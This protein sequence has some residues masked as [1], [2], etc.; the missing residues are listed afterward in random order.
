MQC[1]TSCDV[2]THWKALDEYFQMST[3]LL[4]F[5]SF[6]RFLHHFVLA[7]LATSSIRVKLFSHCL[8]YTNQIRFTEATFDIKTVAWVRCYIWT[9]VL[10]TTCY[11]KTIVP[12][13]H[14][15][16]RLLFHG[17]MLPQDYC[18]MATCYLKTIVT[19]QHVT[20]RLLLH[21]NMLPQDYCYMATCYLKT[22]VTWQH[23]T[24]RLLL[25]GNMLPQDYCY[26]ATC[27]LK[28]IVTWQHV[29]SR[30]LLHGNM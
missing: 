12:W 1:L 2:G 23:V 7:K 9:I 27:Y 29:T 25:H 28:T 14:V 8:T 24:S 6:F 15:T 10:W 11:L 26:M 18:S 22:I 21:G 13:Q 30:L 19:W 16:S 17:N 20:S 4:G 5:P 3:Q